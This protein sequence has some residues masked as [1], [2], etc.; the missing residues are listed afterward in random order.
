MGNREDS[1]IVKPAPEG[2]W[3][4]VKSAGA[5]HIGRFASKNG[6]VL[7]T[8]DQALELLTQYKDW[9]WMNP[10]FDFMAPVRQV[11][12]PD[13]QPGLSR[14]PI[15]MP[16]E[17]L[18]A[19]APMYLKLDGVKFIEDLSKADQETYMGFVKAATDMAEHQRAAKSGLVL[20]GGR[21]LC[22]MRG[23]HSRSYGKSGRP[24]RS[25]ISALDASPY[26]V[27]SYLERAPVAG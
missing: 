2:L 20:E 3:A 10:C 7:K 17:F 12:G 4:V 11:Q 16:H 6:E 9:A 15:I 1:L 24:V 5:L 19:P 25:A 13:G 23:N 26:E 18:T 22:S 21:A 14:S 8:K 27:I